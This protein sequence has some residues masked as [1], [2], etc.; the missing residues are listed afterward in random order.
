MSRNLC[1]LVIRADCSRAVGIGHAMRCL[2]LVQALRDRGG[3]A[4]VAGRLAPAVAK[5]FQR[6]GARLALLPEELSRE[7]DARLLNDV[8]QAAGPGAAVVVDGY[9]FDEAYLAAVSRAGIV[10]AVID[11]YNH[12]PS[13]QT[14]VL[15]NPNPNA[16]SIAYQTAPETLRLLGTAYT[17]LRREFT[18]ACEL[19]AREAP[20]MARHILVTAG[21]AD[22]EGFTLDAIQVLSRCGLP[23]LRVRV[24]L[25]PA[26]R[27]HERLSAR[28]AQ[29]PFSAEALRD[30]E[31]MTPLMSWAHL[32]VTAGGSTCHELACLGVP[33]LACPLA[34]NQTGLCAGYAEAGAG[35]LLD[36]SLTGFVDALG[37]AVARL[38]ED[39][40]AR[41]AMAAAG[42]SLIDGRGAS[43]IVEAIDT[44][45]QHPTPEAT[46]V[47]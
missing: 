6:E 18:K 42:R 41:Q 31:D 19:P 44:L 14:Q 23:G 25:G 39:K 36:H 20:T 33:F 12:L 43:R 7:D 32:A 22:V 1:H 46:H 27:D 37:D 9:T 5:R 40:A 4:T 24:V 45:I 2:A 21:G 15:I 10:T 16:A 35:R 29:A 30:V 38:A 28:L 11:D 17:P 8:C 47:F 34:E 13:Y 26:Y 3:V